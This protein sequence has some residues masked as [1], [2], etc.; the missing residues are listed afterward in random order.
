[1]TPRGIVTRKGTGDDQENVRRRVVLLLL[2]SYEI[3]LK[4]T[5]THLS[6]DKL[7][8]YYY[9]RRAPIRFFRVNVFLLL[10]PGSVRLRS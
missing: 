4:R 6:N 2:F 7:P 10:Q 8:T 3:P 1:M 9:N 5:A